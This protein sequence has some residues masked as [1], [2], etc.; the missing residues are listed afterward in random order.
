MPSS[1]S[2][3]RSSTESHDVIKKHPKVAR[4][5]L[6]EMIARLQRDNAA[7]PVDF[8]GKPVP[9]REDAIR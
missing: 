1:R 6:R 2:S 9:P 8:E 7:Y 5:L 4:R 3:P